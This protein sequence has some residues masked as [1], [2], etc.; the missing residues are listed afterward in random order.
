MAQCAAVKNKKSTD[1][2]AH[3]PLLGHTLCGRHAKCKTVQL[4][5]DVN[6]NKILRFTK[7]Q[8]L[9]R[10]WCVRR[11]LAWA[12][13]GVL[14]RETCVNDE[15]LVTCEPK[16]RQHPMSYFGFE[17]AGKVWWFDF[18][19]AWE[20]TIRSVTP[21]N[22]YTNVP[23]PHADLARLRKLH[24]YRRRK[25]LPV[26][27]PPKDLV[28]N[29]DR[30]WTVVAQIF[31]SYGFEETHPSQFANLNHNNITTMFR[32]LMDDIEAMPIPNR[33]L[34][35]LCSKGALGAHTSNLS[36]LINSLNL[37]T[38]ALTDSQSYDFVF[39][40]LSALYRC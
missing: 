23:I 36:Y 21:L 2:C 37:L 5:A 20:W 16:D 40:L 8:A 15:D 35:A 25:R 18:G 11:V 33:R 29:I 28:E 24:L 14:R 32:F 10:G 27:A 6:R 30:R 22:P 34:L 26:P 17:E 1:R 4:W 31:R 3:G 19:T 7:V 12:G 39:L 9:Y 13:P 38:I